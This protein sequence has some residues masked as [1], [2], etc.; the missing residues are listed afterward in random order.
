MWH[1]HI[2][3]PKPTYTFTASAPVLK[4]FTAVL[5]RGLTLLFPHI[6]HFQAV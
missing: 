6:N 3:P 5:E 4:P 2:S 1:E